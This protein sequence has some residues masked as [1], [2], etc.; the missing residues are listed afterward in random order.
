MLL[1]NNGKKIVT[2]TMQNVRIKNTITGSYP[3]IFHAQGN[4][5]D[6]RDRPEVMGTFFKLLEISKRKCRADNLTIVTCNSS[7][8]KGLF[9]KSLDLLGLDY[10]VLGRGGDWRGNANKLKLLLDAVD[11]IRTDYVLFGDSGDVILFDSPD[12]ILSYFLSLKDCDMLFMAETNHFPDVEAIKT[13]EFEES[14][15]KSPWH[16]LNSGVWIA[17]K[18]RLKELLREAASVHRE[19]QNTARDEYVRTSDQAVYKLLYQRRYPK[20]RIDDRC[21]VFQSVYFHSHPLGFKSCWD[22]VLLENINK[23]RVFSI[24]WKSCLSSESIY[25]HQHTKW[26][27]RSLTRFIMSVMYFWTKSKFHDTGIPETSM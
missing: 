26:R 13:R 16:Y 4:E 20:I 23:S 8:K 19:V 1:Q 11:Y 2:V 15:A 25:S 3:V 10:V 21:E 9:E 24:F 5:S 27:G 6:L 7:L 12:K 17:R 22:F 18:E 14:V